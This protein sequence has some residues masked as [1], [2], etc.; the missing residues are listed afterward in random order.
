LT[1]NHC[2]I[3]Y[4]RFAPVS[5]PVPLSYLGLET[6][7]NFALLSELANDGSRAHCARNEQSI[8]FVSQILRLVTGENKN[9]A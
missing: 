4:E 1:S 9:T 6:L 3:D 7:F 2:V 5:V 8:N